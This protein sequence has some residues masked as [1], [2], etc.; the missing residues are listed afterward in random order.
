MIKFIM[1]QKIKPI[2][3]IT[4]LAI[5]IIGFAVF[6]K[7]AESPTTQ[8]NKEIAKEATKENFLPPATGNINDAINAIIDGATKEQD[9][10]AEEF[11]DKTLLDIDSQTINEFGQSASNYE[12]GI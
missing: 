7:G 8:E 4:V 10:T 5:L 12:N 9:L 11:T 6:Y 1:N 3:I 2:I